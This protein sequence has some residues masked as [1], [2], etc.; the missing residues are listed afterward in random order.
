MRST[1]EQPPATATAWERAALND[2]LFRRPPVPV[3]EGALILHTAMVQ[4]A[5]EAAQ[6]VQRLRSLLTSAELATPGATRNYELL[7]AG[8][9]YLKWERHTEFTTY[10]LVTLPSASDPFVADAECVLPKN[11]MAELDGQRIAATKIRLIASDDHQILSQATQ[12]LR[13]E[14]PSSLVADGQARIWMDC[15]IHPDACTRGIVCDQ[16]LQPDR[17][18]RLVQ[19]LLEI[20]TYRMLAMLGFPPARSVMAELHDLEHQLRV[21]VARVADSEADTDH[22][23]E[24]TLHELLELA[25]EVERLSA[26][27]AYRFDASRAYFDLVQERLD[28][29]REE[30]IQG[31]QRLGNFLGRP[32]RPAIKTVDAVRR[33]LESLSGHI[34]HTASLIRTRVDL[35]LQRQNQHLLHSMDRRAALQLRLQQTLEWLTVVAM[36]YYGIGIVLY[37]AKALGA[38]GVPIE[39]H[40]VAGAAAPLV[41]G[42]AWWLVH[43]VR[44]ML[45]AHGEHH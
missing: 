14:A 36:S 23:D 13:P 21:L 37:I 40:L 12:A 19:R 18:A 24:A 15:S 5:D 38:L 8:R 32:L 3:A 6:S 33:R 4:N 7:H 27:H 25:S 43:I 17:R 34:D 44:A 26:H 22:D 10:T 29:L 45:R 2:E 41:I 1:L 16:G 30:R 42:G 11:W 39:P 31:Y 20:E 28:E 35:R 9:S